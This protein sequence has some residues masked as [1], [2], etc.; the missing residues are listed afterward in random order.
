MAQFRQVSDIVTQDIRQPLAVLQVVSKTLPGSVGDHDAAR[1][2]DI[3][4]RS[5]TRLAEASGKIERLASA[6]AR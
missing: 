5:I 6:A 4:G 1:I 2:M 3:F